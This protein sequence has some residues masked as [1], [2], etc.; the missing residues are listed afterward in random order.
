V[1]DVAFSHVERGHAGVAR[2]DD[3][4]R[5]FDRA[6]A[7]RFGDL[8]QALTDQVTIRAAPD[9]RVDEQRV[10]AASALQVLFHLGD[11]FGADGRIVNAFE[12]L[13]PSADFGPSGQQRCAKAYARR[14]VRVLICSDVDAFGA[15]AVDDLDG[16]RALAPDIGA[17]RFDVRDVNGNLRFA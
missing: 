3:V 10:R 12:H 11:Q 13:L 4:E 14:D 2:F 8:V 9:E 16:F 7:A 17:E 5:S 1:L 6:F 15:G